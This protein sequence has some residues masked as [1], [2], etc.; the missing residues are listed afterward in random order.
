VR[1]VELCRELRLE[2]AARLFEP[3]FRP[4]QVSQQCVQLALDQYQQSEDNYEEDFR[5]KT[6]DSPLVMLGTSAMVLLCWLASLRQFHGC[7]E[8]AD[9]LPIPLP[10]SGNFLGRTTSRANSENHSRCMG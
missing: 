4:R 7:L 5:A 8:A 9:A 3:G 1:G 2:A 10:S 6:H